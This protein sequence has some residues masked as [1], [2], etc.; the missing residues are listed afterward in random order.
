MKANCGCYGKAIDLI[1]LD[2]S[3][4]ELPLLKNTYDI[5]ILNG[6]A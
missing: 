6:V 2:E 5:Q 3:A 1:A 4:I